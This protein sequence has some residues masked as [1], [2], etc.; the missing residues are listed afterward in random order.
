[1]AC[2][3]RLMFALFVTGGALPASGPSAVN[4][5]DIV[6]EDERSTQGEVAEPRAARQTKRSTNGSGGIASLEVP[7]V[8]A[9]THA[10]AAPPTWM[11][12]RRMPLP[13]DDDN[14]AA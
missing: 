1:M 6:E 11:R 2:L 12:P 8:L 9:P 7:S 3:A 4:G 13:D 10:P 14:R 5:F